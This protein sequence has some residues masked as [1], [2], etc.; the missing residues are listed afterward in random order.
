MN[1]IEFI[2]YFAGSIFYT[3]LIGGFVWFI[4]S[5]FRVWKCEG[6]IN[7]LYT[8]LE[9]KINKEK[10]RPVVTA[11]IEGAIKKLKEEYKPKIEELERKR[12]FILDKLPFIK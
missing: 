1:T 5:L 8:E 12:K 11:L 9:T 7:K 3:L 10:E 4:I 6:K 2:Y